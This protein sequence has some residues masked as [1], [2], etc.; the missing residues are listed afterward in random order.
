MGPLNTVTNKLIEQVIRTPGRTPSPQPAHYSVQVGNGQ[1]G[2]GGHHNKILRS[3]T[4]GY[5]AP[6]F[7]GKPQQMEQ[8]EKTPVHQQTK[9]V[10]NDLQSRR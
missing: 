6:K 3:A 2:N 4:L 9:Q 10:A 8:G 5:E 1:N 7:E